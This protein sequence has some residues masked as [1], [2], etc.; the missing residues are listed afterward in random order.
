VTIVHLAVGWGAGS[1]RSAPSPAPSAWRNGTRP[2]ASRRRSAPAP[3][4]P[5]SAL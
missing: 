2:C 4:S 3:A 1:S 5:E